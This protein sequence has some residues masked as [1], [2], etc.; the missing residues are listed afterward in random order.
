MNDVESETMSNKRLK[1]VYDDENRSS[2]ISNRTDRTIAN[3]KEDE[4]VYSLDPL[5]GALPSRSLVESLFGLAMEKGPGGHQYGLVPVG[6]LSL[7]EVLLPAVAYQAS[8]AWKARQ[9]KIQRDCP[10]QTE[11]ILVCRKLVFDCIGS[12]M[13]AVAASRKERAV[14][15]EE[16]EA[17]WA[18]AKEERAQERERQLD[19]AR[20]GRRREA[21][22]KSVRNQELWREM[23]YLMTEQAKLERE[24]AQWKEAEQELLQRE[25]DLQRQEEQAAMKQAAL[26]KE[27]AAEAAASKADDTNSTDAGPPSAAMK[28]VIESVQAIVLSS[29]RIQKALEVVA[30]MLSESDRVRKELYHRYR[31]DHQFHGY[32]GVKNTKDLV[33]ALSQPSQ[34]SFY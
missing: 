34:D 24:E 5:N 27:N 31:K 7:E 19:R 3:A 4:S 32:Q 29:S 15:D 2:S 17:A 13:Q 26:D 18:L 21:Q 11:S 33:R 1:T 30:K 23:V 8:E 22:K 25:Q 28:Q 16:R 12:A 9:A 6:L 14:Q 20:E 10:N